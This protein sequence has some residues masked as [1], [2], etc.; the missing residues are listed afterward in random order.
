MVQI[1]PINFGLIIAYVLPGTVGIYSLRYLS[2]HV[3][4]LW[5]ALESGQAMAGP[6]VVLG[7]ASL[8]VGLTVSS[9][10]VV[11]LEGIFYRTGVRK[12]T[13]SYE[14][15]A[16]AEKLEL[17]KEMVENVY[18]YHQFYGNVMLSLLFFSVVRYTVVK[19]PIFDSVKNFLLFATLVLGIITLTIAARKLLADVHKAI[20]DLCR[21]NVLVGG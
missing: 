3:N 20:D 15:I 21:S 4:L 1:A 19:A 7:I 16:A 9:L 17:F 12:A 10:R 13:I 14:K 5:Q 6:L 11:V 8:V 2:D 18:R